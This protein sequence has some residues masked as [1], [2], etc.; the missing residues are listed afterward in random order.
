MILSTDIFMYLIDMFD[1]YVAREDHLA[2]ASAL[3]PWPLPGEQGLII[4][5]ACVCLGCLHHLNIRE[6]LLAPLLADLC[7]CIAAVAQVDVQL[8][9]AD[10]DDECHDKGHHGAHHAQSLT[11]SGAHFISI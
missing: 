10:K 6:A 11:K 2:I 3:C 4:I 9:A 5:R 8:V 7:E 1:R